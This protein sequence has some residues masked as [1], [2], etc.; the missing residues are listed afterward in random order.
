MAVNASATDR[1]PRPQPDE[2]TQFYWDAASDHRLALQRCKACGRLQFPP[3]VVCIHCQSAHFEHA[4]TSGRG[5]IFSFTIVDRALHVGFA[6]SLP[7]IVALVEL[8]DQP[9]LRIV[10]N[11]V[12]AE[13]GQIAVG[14]PVEV[15]FEQR[16][17]VTLPQ[18]RLAGSKA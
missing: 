3:E 6:D 18:F 2:L 9:G 8:V 15:T 13:P 16:G 10:A 11:V 12:D 17:D 7:Y 5:T 4:D 1:R 14:D